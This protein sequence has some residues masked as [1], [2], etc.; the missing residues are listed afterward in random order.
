MNHMLTDHY[1]P[2]AWAIRATEQ[3][4]VETDLYLNFY[5]IGG[6][7]IVA[8]YF[9]VIGFIHGRAIKANTLGWLFA[10]MLMTV[11]MISHLRGSLFNHT[12]FYLYPYTLA[13][14]FIFGRLHLPRENMEPINE[15]PASGSGASLLAHRSE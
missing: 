6:L 14:L 10:S 13:M 11:W 2:H 3:W 8:M 1:Y 5:F 7:P 12:D 4:P 9:Y 15:L